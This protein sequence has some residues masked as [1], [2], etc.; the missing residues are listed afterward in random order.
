MHTNTIEVL[1]GSLADRSPIFARGN[2]LISMREN[3]VIAIVDPTR[4]IVVWA[5]AGQWLGQHQ[6]SLLSN[7][8]ILLL[9]NR[10]HRGMSKVIEIEPF[11]QEIVWSY[12]GNPSNGFST[13]SGGSTQRLPNGNTLITESDTGRAF[14]VTPSGERVWEYYNGSRAG[15]KGELVATLCEVVRLERSFT[16]DWMGRSNPEAH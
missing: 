10:G 2:I 8:N 9:D 15:E 6:P 4:E 5:L 11:S 1:D 13:N 7:G 14:E 16:A 12:E 3:N